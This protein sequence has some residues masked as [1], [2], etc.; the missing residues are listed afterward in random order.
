M[1]ENFKDLKPTDDFGNDDPVSAREAAVN[2][3][4]TLIQSKVLNSTGSVQLQWELANLSKYADQIQEAL[5]VK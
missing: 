4:L 3:A 5:K 1:S 2:A